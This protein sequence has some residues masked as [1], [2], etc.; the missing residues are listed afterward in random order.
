MNNG[1]CWICLLAVLGWF[2]LQ[3]GIGHLASAQEETYDLAHDEVFGKLQ[4]PAVSFPHEEH[5]DLLE[6][7]GCGACHHE[8]DEEQGT[9]VPVED[10]DTGCAECHGAKKA[11][12]V[13][14]LREAYHGRCTGCH[15][16]RAKAGE[17][18]GPITCGEC[19]RR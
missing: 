11:D 5:M 3:A 8:Y 6:E 4:R 1:R 10:P 15:R 12:G 16:D 13:P 2:S 18:T 14:G 19:H 17:K 7:E 9:L